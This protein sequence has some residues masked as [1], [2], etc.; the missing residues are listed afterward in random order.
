MT[1]VQDLEKT[2]VV[3]CHVLYDRSVHG[4]LAVSSDRVA[5]I[6]HQLAER[7][8][9]LGYVRASP[10]GTADLGLQLL[11]DGKPV[12][13]VE[14]DGSRQVFVVPPGQHML[15][16]ASRNYAAVVKIAIIAADAYEVIPADHPGLLLGWG[17]C[18]REGD[19]MW[20]CIMGLAGLPTGDIVGG[21]QIVVY[22]KTEARTTQR[23]GQN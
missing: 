10:G 4:Q 15:H 13:P 23:R 19:A 12:Q 2:A 1:V 8:A 17:P 9:R 16:L 11:I 3:Y 14:I 7:A 18:E 21:T 22:L 20:R 6:W 5:P